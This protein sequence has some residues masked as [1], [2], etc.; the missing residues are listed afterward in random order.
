MST[1]KLLRFALILAAIG[2]LTACDRDNGPKD[3]DKEMEQSGE[4][5]KDQLEETKSGLM[6]EA[7][8]MDQSTEEAKKKLE[9]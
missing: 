7:S 5:A 9:E 2:T 6:D 8:E 4:M 3:A 1:L